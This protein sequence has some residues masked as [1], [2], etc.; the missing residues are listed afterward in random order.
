VSVIKQFSG[1]LKVFIIIIT[2][3]YAMLGPFRP[4]EE[5]VGPTILT[6]GALCFVVLLACMFTFSFEFV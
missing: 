5:Y 2:V 3:D 1:N 4:L 6:V